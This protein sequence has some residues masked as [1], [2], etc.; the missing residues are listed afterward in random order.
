[1][2][3]SL[4]RA[5]YFPMYWYESVPLQKNVF[6]IWPPPLLF[7]KN[8]SLSL[9]QLACSGIICNAGD[10]LAEMLHFYSAYCIYL[11]HY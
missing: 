10:I 2:K 1:M 8:C 6:Y 7:V 9:K 5:P 4:L 11:K 3:R